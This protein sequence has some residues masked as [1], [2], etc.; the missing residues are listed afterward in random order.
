ME[1]RVPGGRRR[2]FAGRVVAV[3]G[4]ASGL[5][6]AFARR[7]ARA[8]A[9]LALLD[10]DGAAA[11]RTATELEAAGAECLAVA[12][13]VSDEA[14][15]REAIAAV[16]RR[17]GGLDVLV[18]N[19]GITHRSAFAETGLDV[20]RR[21]LGVN[22]FGPLHCTKAALAS[23]VERRGLVVVVSSIA[24]VA[25]LYGRTGYAASKHALHGL[26]GSLRAELAPAGVDV[27]IVCP[28][29]TATNL[30][31]AALDADGSVTRH[32]QSTVGR[33]ATPES[34][35]DAVFDAAARGRRL[36]VL[37]AAGRAAY[38]LNRLWPALY[39]RLMARSLRRELER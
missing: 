9:K 12:C 37:S 26:F 14:S 32:P 4:G 10:L 15:A 3:T 19:A 22:F 31:K 35:A 23:L 29:F 25:P 24:G 36:L 27:L 13:D 17:F 5:G 33:I 11:Q 20:Y 18:N 6:A 7:F 8:G 21:V 1:G 16:T 34:V 38:L 39:E 30:S 28:G 2:E